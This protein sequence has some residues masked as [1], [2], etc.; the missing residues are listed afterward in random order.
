M[1]RT[2]ADSQPYDVL[3]AAIA[4]RAHCLRSRYGPA[5][6]PRPTLGPRLGAR[7]DLDIIAELDTRHIDADGARR[8]TRHTD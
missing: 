2:E 7:A 3:D 5:S 6:G 4:K 8:R 1:T